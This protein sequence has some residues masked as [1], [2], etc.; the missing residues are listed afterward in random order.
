MPTVFIDGH[1]GTTGLKIRERLA[2]RT[3]IA[4]SEIPSED[5][6][7]NEV[8]KCYLD[9]A[10]IVII[11]LPDTAAKESVALIGNPSTRVIDASTAHRVAEGWVYGMA[12]LDKG[13]RER[14]RGASRV[15]NP[16]CYATGFIAALRPLIAAGVVPADYPV[17][18]CAT[19]GYSGAG[20]KLIQVYSENRAPADKLRAPRPYAM[21]L[22]HK[23]VPEMQKLA[24]LAHPPLFMPIVGDFYQGMTVH[25]PLL[26][27]LLPGRSGPAAIHETLAAHYAG[28]RFVRVMPL[29]DDSVLD[30]GFLAAMACNE[31][32]RMDLFV[33]GHA[34]QVQVVAV[35]DNLGKGA[36]G[37]AVQNLNIM[38]GLDE[39]AGLVA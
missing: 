20:K 19:S 25:V 26:T 4:V 39:S 14:I 11:C 10:D 7:N 21:A 30:N 8:K 1:E 27:R 12:E 5:R 18:C 24:G 2:G 15:T 13:Q 3:D 31:T 34:E 33:F 6:K 22:G 29:G 38:L 17:T 32:N 36:S 16:G 28:E 23:H 35:L 9:G 37:A